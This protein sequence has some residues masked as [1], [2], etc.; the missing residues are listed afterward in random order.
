MQRLIIVTRHGFRHPKK[1][2]NDG[3][4]LDF[5]FKYLTYDNIRQFT[6]VENHKD[7][8]FLTQE[9]YD[10]AFNNAKIIQ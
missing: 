1:L 5:N 3:T 8:A 6:P 9:G 10:L 2:P 4:T 7:R